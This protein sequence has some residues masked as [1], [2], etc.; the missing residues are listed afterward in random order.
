MLKMRATLLGVLALLIVSGI[1]SASASALGPYW[2]S[3]GIKMT[4]STVQTELQNKGNAV[5]KSEVTG[6]GPVTIECGV[7]VS[8]G[9]T[10]EGNGNGQG[11]G[12][13]RIKFSSCASTSCPVA[14]PINTSQTKS[15]LVTY[16]GGQTKY[17][18]LFEP[19]QGTVFTVIKLG[20]AC[21]MALN[22]V[23][24]VAAEILPVESESQNGLL[25]FPPTPIPK[26]FLEQ[27]EK[28]V[29]LT[30]GP[31]AAVFSATF[32]VKATTQFGVYG[33]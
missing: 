32:G 19:T 14:E 33:Q 9:A 18:L 21:A 23:G 26:V 22:V 6:V 2:H 7:A 17:A 1:S 13:G 16:K 12:K 11:Q 10:V 28:T 29:G 27:Q 20:G 31:K 25:V 24:S 3:N 4:Q 5:L 8:E 30:L 15:H